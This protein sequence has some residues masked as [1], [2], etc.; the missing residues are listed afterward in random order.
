MSPAD[1]RGEL[2]VSPGLS[3]PLSEVEL[4]AMRAQGPGGQNVNKVESAVH[5]RFDIHAS[6]LPVAHKKRLLARSDQRISKEGVVVIKAQGSR[7]QE[8][9]RQEALER[10]KE[11]LAATAR[12]PKKRIPTRPTRA[13][14]RRRIER[15][16]RLGQLKALRGRVREG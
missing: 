8:R 14:R 9:N 11:L 16:R 13:S 6:S 2:R 4:T 7:R 10:L 3:I 15:K 5:L 12:V 1:D